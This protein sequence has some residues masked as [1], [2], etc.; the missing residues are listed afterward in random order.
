M[1]RSVASNALT[2]FVVILIGL[3]VAV[4]MAQREWR[5]PG[6]LAEAVCLSVP[7]GATIQ[8][9]SEDLV[10]KGAVRSGMLLRIGA[11]YTDR[12]GKLKAGNFLIPPRA[13]PDDI[14]GLVTSGGQSTCGS[15]IN[16]RI[17]V[18]DAAVQMRELDPASG[19]FTVVA[20]YP[21]AD[22]APAEVQ[23]VLDAGFA[24]TRV[25]VAE[26]V[27]SWRIA[28]SLQKASFLGGDVAE[29]PDEGTLAPGSYEVTIG[30]DR[31][32]LLSQM[33]ARQQEILTAAWAGR[34][35]GLPLKNAYEALIL[36]S[37][38]EKETRIADE[39]PV[40]ASVF[41]NRL[42]EGMRLQTDPT[43]IYGLTD[44]KGVLGRGLYRSELA[45]PTPYNTYVIQG[46]PPT[47]IANPGQDSIE[48]VVR[49]ADTEFLFFVADGTGGH[50][51]S[52]TL[53]E[54]NQNV[55]KWRRIEQQQG[56]QQNQ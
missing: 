42:N 28:D 47:P 37:I 16:L 34:A 21:V 49:P 20:E 26:G 23:T 36:A 5:S 35:N 12:A 39:R 32:A 4:A 45:R 46:L 50:V 54:H 15:D 53:A 17:G 40:V 10:A 43:V 3:G 22:P 48:A 41:E 2:L 31:D 11:E 25:T 38:V 19:E 56:T 6:P 1:W 55:Q 44:G 7:R 14:V 52:K 33:A 13:S 51:F 27:T 30:G 9:V 8:T 24:R 29:V 18:A